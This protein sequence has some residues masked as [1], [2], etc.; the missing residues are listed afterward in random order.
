MPV[1]L[2]NELRQ[3]KQI[4]VF[5]RELEIIMGE[6]NKGSDRPRVLVLGASGLN[7]GAI[8]TQLSEMGAVEVVRGARDPRTVASWKD[9]GKP[10]VLIDLDDPQSFPAALEGIDRL[11]LMTGYTIHMVHQM[12]TITDAAVDAGVSFIVHLGVFGNGR[13]TDPHFAWH[14]LVERYIEGSGVAW[15]HLHP[16]V[17]MENLLTVMRPVDGALR[18]PMGDK[19]VGWVA[20]DDIAA[21][22]AKVLAEGPE[23][24]AGKNYYLS[25]D[26]LNG[27]EV[28]RVLSRA[29]DRPIEALVMTPDDL[30]FGVASGQV[31]MPGNI[32][33]NYAASMLEWARQT[34]D[35]RM[36]YSAV[37]T[38]TVA[39][40]LGRPP[41]KLE[42]W[43]RQHRS[44]IGA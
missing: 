14:E 42:A 20:S 21:V 33:A 12:K 26:V 31:V 1:V 6:R 30:A 41:I 13:S 4:A 22:A 36:A 11:F 25:T 27:I 8:V 10:A 2:G 5:L 19:R 28:A 16:H 15:C 29:T 17:F 7:G 34:F 18:W 24:H 23:R 39:T 38:G 44:D 9:Q 3:R 32:E 40:L 37:T 35:G 43:A